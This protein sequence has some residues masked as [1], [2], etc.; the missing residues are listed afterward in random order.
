MAYA[1]REW[2]SPAAAWDFSVMS[3]NLLAE[4]LLRKYKHLY[5]EC[6]V[7]T[8]D[9]ATRSGM[10]LSEIRHVQPDIVCLQEVQRD[11]FG[12]CYAGFFDANGYEAL[13]VPRTRRTDGCA[14]AFKRDR[15]E[16]L[17]ETASSA[18]TY[19]FAGTGMQGYDYG[20]V[21]QLAFLCARTTPPRVLCVANT[22][23][24]FD[25]RRGDIKLLQVAMLLNRIE[26]AACVRALADVPIVLCGD[27][28]LQPHSPIYNFITEKR[29]SYC[30]LGR[31]AVSRKGALHS[32]LLAGQDLIGHS[33]GTPEET[34]PGWL[35]QMISRQT[36]SLETPRA[37]TSVAF[38]SYTRRRSSISP[39]VAQ[40]RASIDSVPQLLL[41]PILE[42]EPTSP[43]PLARSSTAGDPT[44]RRS[45]PTSQPFVDMSPPSSIGASALPEAEAR[46][47]LEQASA[48]LANYRRPRKVTLSGVRPSL[49][50][51]SLA[52]MI[53]PLPVLPTPPTA[54]PTL[55]PLP[56]LPTLG[57]ATP[58]TLSVVTTRPTPA[59]SPSVRRRSVFSTPPARRGSPLM[60]ECHSLTHGLDL[61]SVYSHVDAEGL[62][63]MTTKFDW[64]T[65]DFMFFTPGGL[66]VAS[67]LCLMTA[68]RVQALGGMP[69]AAFPSDH[70][71]LVARFCWCEPAEWADSPVAT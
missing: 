42:D 67:P 28:N 11:H 60:V 13:F 46:L 35:V 8:L 5:A 33:F 19:E 3:F 48:R 22:H 21:G 53:P 34:L 38:P 27:F 25:P 10:I 24:L 16:L 1:E 43:S 55:P 41:P 58:A 32:D 71:A 6:N 12:S 62:H 18:I 17:D 65:V 69:G 66:R 14:I 2:A 36:D 70:Q 47:E 26:A 68:S 50:T 61:R 64:E 54:M 20:N 15:F 57:L 30:K 63:E 39:G 40:L 9:W 49:S 51:P 45:Q 7:D 44:S 31:L 56:T 52:A 23:I 59:V 29:L 37:R 4:D